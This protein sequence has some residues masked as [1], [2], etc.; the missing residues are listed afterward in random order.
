[1]LVRT[2]FVQVDQP[3]PV[4]GVELGRLARGDSFGERSVLMDKEEPATI[5]AATFVV[6]YEI[7]KAQL[8]A[9]TRLLPANTQRSIEFL[10]EG[11]RSVEE[12]KYEG[13]DD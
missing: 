4:P 12:A 2:G 7:E 13:R 8:A 5:K 9:V 1:M 10:Q 11:L 6:I 3:G